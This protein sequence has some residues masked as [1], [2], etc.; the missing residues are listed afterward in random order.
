MVFRGTRASFSMP[1][2]RPRWFGEV[3]RVLK[4]D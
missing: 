3:T 4:A 2:R 1:A